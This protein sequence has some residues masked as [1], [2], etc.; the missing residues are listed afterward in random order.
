MAAELERRQRHQLSTNWEEC[1]PT[2]PADARPVA[3]RSVSGAVLNAIGEKVSELIGGSADLTGSNNTALQDFPVISAAR[4]DGR[5]LHFGVREH[6]MGAILN[7]MALSGLLRPYAGT[8][9]VFSDYMRASIRL[10]AIMRLP[11]VYVFTHDSIFLGEDGP[12]HQPESH[13]PSLRAIPGLTVFRPADAR[14]TVEAWR[15][16]IAQKAGPTALILTRQKLPVLALTADMAEEGVRRGGYVLGEAAGDSQAILL[17]T[18]SEVSLALDAQK[19]LAEEDITVRVVSLPSWE[20]F[21]QQSEAYRK[22][23]LPPSLSKRLAIE[24]GS[25]LGW[26]RYVGAEGE[27]HS[28]DGFGASAPAGD[29]AKEFGFTTASVVARVKSMLARSGNAE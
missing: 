15:C 25:P 22:A 8:F 12:T 17:A 6:A 18:G 16:A 13:L 5:N 1:L 20:I 11:V 14:E 27:I 28:I 7:G 23:V 29:L 10:A 21:A 3:T 19:A 26:E 2:F 9:L 4:Q 24:A